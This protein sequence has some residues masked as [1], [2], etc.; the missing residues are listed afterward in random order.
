MKPCFANEN[1][2]MDEIKVR[3]GLQASFMFGETCLE[4]E[5][6]VMES[7]ES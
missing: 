5:T 3:G 6:M 1:E 4:E 2:R 7:R